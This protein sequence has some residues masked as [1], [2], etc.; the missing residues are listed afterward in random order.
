MDGQNQDRSVEQ[1]RATLERRPMETP[2]DVAVLYS[3]ANLHG[4]KYRDFSA[5]RREYRAQMRHRAAEQEA[6]VELQ[7]KRDAEAAE[8]VAADKL[9]MESA[10][11]RAVTESAQHKAEA[12]ALAAKHAAALAEAQEKLQRAE[13]EMLAAREA[14]AAEEALYA[15]RQRR[16]QY[17]KEHP[18]EF[19]VTITDPYVKPEHDSFH[20]EHEMHRPA[21]GFVDTRP[22]PQHHM[23]LHPS[24]VPTDNLVMHQ[25]DIGPP[26][27]THV[28]PEA[29][30]YR[31]PE[32]E[33]PVFRPRRH[34]HRDRL[35][36]RSARIRSVRS[37]TP[38][39]I[40]TSRPSSDRSCVHCSQLSPCPDLNIRSSR[41]GSMPIA[42]RW[43][44]CSGHRR[45][46][47]LLLSQTRCSI[48]VSVWLR[49]G[50][51]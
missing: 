30:P 41:R 44:R 51:R 42:H 11:H 38:D 12:A 16:A 27:H 45:R 21:P 50:S 13:R 37:S 40:R 29:I 35:R 43:S 46:L 23:V 2:E 14:A 20:L 4:A 25:T 48:R 22:F 47:R 36:T 15:E 32:P 10:E 1:E 5:S 26:M 9:R 49:A 7:A 3:W 31:S 34:R 6:E 8:K 24:D 28:V 33:Y 18:Q 19:R 39:I 17:S